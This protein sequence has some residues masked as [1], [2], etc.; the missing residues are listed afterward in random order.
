MIIMALNCGSSSVKYQLYDWNRKEVVAKGIVERVT[1]GDSFIVHEVPGRDVFEEEHACPTHQDA[2]D[3][4]I[5]T[6]TDPKRG[7]IKD[8]SEI[9]AVGHR[10]VH[11]GEKFT[12]SVVIDDQVLEAVKEC[13]HLAPLHNP[14][15]IEGVLAARA[16]LPTVPQV[17]VFDTAFHQ[18]MP[19]HA[20]IYPVPYEWY[21]KHQVR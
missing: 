10:I 1:I 14:P 4:I 18:T 20:Y 11:G 5:R 15:N 19:D 2:I 16:L 21:Q 6:V 13:Q 8:V 17:A 9:A 12:C 7:V 3:L